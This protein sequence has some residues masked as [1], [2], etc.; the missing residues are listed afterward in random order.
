[1]YTLYWIYIFS[2][3]ISDILLYRIKWMYVHM[4]VKTLSSL[5]NN[6]KWRQIKQ[7]SFPVSWGC[8]IHRLLLYRGLRP[9]THKYSKQ[10]DGEIPVMPELWGMRTTPSLP[11]LPAPLWPGVVAPDRVISMGQIELNWVGWDGTV[12]SF[13]LPTYAKLNYLK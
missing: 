13:K 7:Y 12:S 11:S 3:K 4:I 6:D 10:S 8:R 5:L 1:M 9:P 2:I